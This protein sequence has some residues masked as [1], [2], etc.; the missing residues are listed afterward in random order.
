M[1]SSFG[2]STD[3]DDVVKAFADRVKGRTFLVTGTTAGGLGANT[4]LTLARQAPAHI[5]LVSRTRA[6]TEPVLSELAREAPGVRATFVPCELSDLD[7]VRAAADQINGDAGVGAIDV[8]INNAGVMAI[9][10]KT[11]KQGHELTLSSNH[12]GHFLL[13]NLILPKVLAAGPGARVVNLSSNGHRISN[14][15]FDDPGFS[16]GDAYEKWTAYGQSKTA[17]VLFSVVLAERLGARGVFSFSVHPGGIYDTGLSTH[18]DEAE[19]AT[20]KAVAERNNWPGVFVLD[21]PKTLAQGTSPIVAAALD[22]EFEARNGAFIDNCQFGRA[23]AYALDGEAARR[24]WV[25]SE[26][27]VGEKFDW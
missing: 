20:I 24:L 23:E 8:V 17:N 21:K 26:E 6:K 1:P 10:Y 15:R 11:D 13:T 16:G 3:C 2:F 27:L 18:L 14:F 9:P 25:L 22:P 5:I 19:F 12:L 4:V 7:S